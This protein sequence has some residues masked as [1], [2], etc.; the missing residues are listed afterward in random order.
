[1]QDFTAQK[2]LIVKLF[3]AVATLNG[4]D[5]GNIGGRSHAQAL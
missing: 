4:F 2:M 1:V 3:E 5:T